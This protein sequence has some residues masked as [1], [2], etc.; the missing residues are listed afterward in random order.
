MKVEAKRVLITG[1]S[2]TVGAG[3]VRHLGPLLPPD[4][5]ITNGSDPEKGVRFRFDD[6]HTWNIALDGVSRVFL[7]RPPAMSKVR[8]QMGPFLAALAERGPQLVV[9][10]SVQGADTLSFVPHAAIEQMLTVLKLPSVFLRP[11]FFMQNLTGAHRKEIVEQ[12]RIV[13][14]AGRGS[15]NFVDTDD[16]AR[17]AARLLVDPKPS[18]G[19]RAYTLTGPRSW[20]YEEIAQI[21]SADLGRNITYSRPGILRFLAHRR[22]LG[23]PWGQVITMA[24]LYTITRLGLAPATLSPDLANLLDRPPHSLE[25]WIKENID[26]W[27]PEQIPLDSRLPE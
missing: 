22:R 17:V 26:Q 2:G 5:Q 4:W 12:D 18:P 24:A 9:F 23:T 16:I 13:V 1:A 19:Q 15:T 11:S 14:P 3:V 7:M 27:M 8:D 6:P 21:L 10:L 20:T 25:D